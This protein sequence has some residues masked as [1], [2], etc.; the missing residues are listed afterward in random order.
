[1]DIRVASVSLRDFAGLIFEDSM[2]YLCF[3]CNVTIRV[4]Y[5]IQTNGTLGYI[6]KKIKVFGE[7]QDSD[8]E[9][10]I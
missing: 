3:S 8:G 1:M 2:E 7:A 10:H 4:V 9:V 5:I 6:C